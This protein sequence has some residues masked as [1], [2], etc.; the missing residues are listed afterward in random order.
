MSCSR[1]FRS[2]FLERPT[3]SKPETGALTLEI[4]HADNSYMDYNLG[5]TIEDIFAEVDQIDQI[6]VSL[7]GKDFQCG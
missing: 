4:A 3:A 5:E 6:V 1:V 7:M 2:C